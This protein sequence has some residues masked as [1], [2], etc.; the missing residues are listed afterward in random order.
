[1]LLLVIP[2][3]AFIGW[4]IYKL[5]AIYM[6]AKKEQI[7]EEAKSGVSDEAKDAIIKEYLAKMQ[8]EQNKSAENT[9]EAD[10]TSDDAEK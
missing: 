10:N 5:I 4:Q 9:N 8:A 7:I 2:M 1:M 3:L 6:A